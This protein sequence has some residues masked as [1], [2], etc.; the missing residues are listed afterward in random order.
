MEDKGKN[1]TKSLFSTY[2]YQDLFG[3]IKATEDIRNLIN[4]IKKSSKRDFN[5]DE[6]YNFFRQCVILSGLSNKYIYSG[7]N[8]SKS[9]FHKIYDGKSKRVPER[10]VCIMLAFGLKLS[11]EDANLFIKKSRP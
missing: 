9:Y 1:G 8:I 10:N 2:A 6:F 4:K 3:V 5:D 7:A 11:I